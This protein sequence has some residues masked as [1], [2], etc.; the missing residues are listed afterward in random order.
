VLLLRCRRGRGLFVL[1]PGRLRCGRAG[2]TDLRRPSL[3]LREHRG[4][5]RIWHPLDKEAQPRVDVQAARAVHEYWTE[6]Q[7][8]KALTGNGVDLD[9]YRLEQPARYKL[10]SLPPSQECG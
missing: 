5:R 7:R 1:V 2:F 3:E 4:K 8:R 6:L 9:S 10:L